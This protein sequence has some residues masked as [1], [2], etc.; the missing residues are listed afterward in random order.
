MRERKRKTHT[1]TH[2][3]RERERIL[4]LTFK[5]RISQTAKEAAAVPVG[6]NR[7]QRECNTGYYNY[8]KYISPQCRIAISNPM[9]NP[10]QLF[11]KIQERFPLT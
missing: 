1:Q 9:P 2:I 8:T 4:N 10:V 7:L 3:E 5:K 6:I 11:H